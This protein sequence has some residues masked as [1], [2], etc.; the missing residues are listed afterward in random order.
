MRE[1]LKQ[2]REA[3]KKRG[4]TVYYQP[5][6]DAHGSEEISARD[7]SVRKISGFTG[8]SCTLVVLEKEAFIWTD[9]RFFVQ[10]NIE[11]KDSGVELMKAGVPGTPT[12]VE[13]LENH[14]PEGGTLAFYAP[15]LGTNTG[16]EL[17]EFVAKKKGKLITD[18]DLVD[19]IWKDRP[20]RS[21]E[22]IWVHDIKYAGEEAKSKIDRVQAEM[23]K[24][25]ASVFLTGRLDE[26]SWV[27]N[28]HG[29]DISCN[30]VFLSYLMVKARS[31]KLFCQENALT[32]EAKKHLEE[33]GIA[34]GSYDDFIAAVGKLKDER[35]LTDLRD[36]NFAV[37][38]AVVDKNTIVDELSPIS[39]MKIIKNDTELKGF[40]DCHVRDGVHLTRFL[41]WLK[42][43]IKEGKAD[44]YTEYDLGEKLNSFRAADPKYVTLS[45]STIPAYQANAAMAHYMPSKEQSDVV[46][47]EGLFLVDS[48]AHYLDGTTDVTRTLALG[49][50]T[51]EQSRDYTLAVIGML[52]LMFAVFP[53]Y[54]TA[55][56]LDTYARQ[57]M[58][59][60]GRDYGHGTGHGVGFV[61]NVHELPVSVRPWP[62]PDRR[63]E[64]T[65]RPGMV[66]S[67]EPGVYIDGAYGIRIENML[68]CVKDT[69]HEGFNCFENLTWA[70]LDPDALDLSVM[71]KDDIRRFNKYQ[72]R[73][74]KTIAPLLPEEEREWLIHETRKIRRE[75]KH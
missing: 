23:K 7:Q 56:L 67:D 8:D 34:V 33:Q 60:F 13:Y 41:Y 72:K 58:W 63:R 70:P 5:Y 53:Y 55:P 24:L 42:K 73:V 46:K 66:T 11:L 71:S 43:T 44:T 48:G 47:P 21:H 54:A 14:F 9:S 52:N 12:I 2:L 18:I 22:P 57:A 62:H 30:P 20:E 6:S 36:L 40:R 45:F 4:I 32:D 50:I 49:D 27:T 16:K 31:A 15:L 74:R 38:N 35:V 69:E 25:D 59:K 28:L 1:E 26:I 65:F 3:M 51:P 68:I 29:A 64:V 19:D 61:N 17:K 37:Y 75:K 39:L 10:A